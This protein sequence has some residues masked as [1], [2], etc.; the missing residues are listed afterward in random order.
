[1][2]FRIDKYYVRKWNFSFGPLS[3]SYKL[4]GLHRSDPEAADVPAPGPPELELPRTAISSGTPSPASSDD[5][6]QEAEATDFRV[7][8]VED[9]Y[10]AIRIRREHDNPIFVERRGPAVLVRGLA[11]VHG[12]L[13][14]EDDMALSILAFEICLAVPGHAQKRSLESLKFSLEVRAQQH[15]ES[16]TEDN[17]GSEPE[18]IDYSP[19]AES[20]VLGER[21][22]LITRKLW[23]DRP[24]SYLSGCVWLWDQL[25]EDSTTEAS[26]PRSYRVAIA[27]RNPGREPF[28]VKA[29]VQTR[30]DMTHG[31]Q[32]PV[33]FVGQDIILVVPRPPTKGPMPVWDEMGS[34]FLEKLLGTNELLSEVPPAAETEVAE[35]KKQ[36]DAAENSDQHSSREDFHATGSEAGA[37]EEG[38]PD[39]T[40]KGTAVA[41]Q[42]RH[43]PIF[44]AP[45]NFRASELSIDI[46]GVSFSLAR[47]G[48]GCAR[49]LTWQRD[50]HM[51]LPGWTPLERSETGM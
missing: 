42:T 7:P 48:L 43:K 47:S 50:L 41:D 8:L 17:I 27:I 33:P 2:E 32:M 11:Q 25:R 9:D 6:I 28:M 26:Q 20:E 31:V 16:G 45:P 38:T 4:G 15:E 37:I 19:R 3:A 22:E 30:L 49:T 14:H 29:A 34:D 46:L 5:E 40:A 18:V 1:M 39:N 12:Q 51:R 21:A 44:S 23:T 36:H 13:S 35:E 10:G 24:S